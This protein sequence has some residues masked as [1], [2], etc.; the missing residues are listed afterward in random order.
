[1]KNVFIRACLIACAMLSMSAAS[2]GDLKGAFKADNGVVFTVPADT[3]SVACTPGSVTVTQSNT[4]ARSFPDASG[5][6]CSKVTTSAG[7]YESYVQ[8]PGTPAGTKMF[9][10]ANWI[11]AYCKATGAPQGTLI[12]YPVN[13]GATIL[14]DGCQTMAQISARAN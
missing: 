5:A 7:F 14:A 10:A 1:M 3:Q 6:V 9:Y 2:A 11:E 4:N 13:G 12:S 8:Q